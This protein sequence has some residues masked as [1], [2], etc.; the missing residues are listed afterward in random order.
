MSSIEDGTVRIRLNGSDQDS[1]LKHIKDYQLEIGGG[2][3]RRLPQGGFGIDVYVAGA[4]VEELQ[5]NNLVFEVIENATTIGRE[6][7]KEVGT[8]DRFAG[9]TIAPRGLG[10]KE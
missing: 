6:R 9:G 1:L 4:R 7:Q 8:G 3:T 10:K 5:R 2:G